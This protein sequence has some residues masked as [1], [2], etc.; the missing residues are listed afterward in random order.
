M[1]TQGR[2]RKIEVTPAWCW[3][4]CRLAV[5]LAAM[6]VFGCN[7]SNDIH[8]TAYKTVDSA[9]TFTGGPDE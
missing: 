5:I 6:G 7:I 1:W 8:V 9:Q 3:A 4:G 2:M